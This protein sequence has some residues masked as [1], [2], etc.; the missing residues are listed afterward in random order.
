MRDI[1]T[2]LGGAVAGAAII[3]ALA[4]VFVTASI[5]QAQAASCSNMQA[6]WYGTESGSRTA[7]GERFDG[8]SLTAASR[9]LPFN[10]RLRVTYQ[11][12]SVVVRINDRGPFHRDKHGRYDR[13]LD[14]SHA[15][16]K[17]LGTIPAGVA[18]VLVC[19]LPSR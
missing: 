14:L 16:A 8:T 13:D 12:K 17:A 4:Y 6:S 19:R 11:G 1:W 9:T 10:T 3:L 15:V 5:P 18:T 7:N 2:S